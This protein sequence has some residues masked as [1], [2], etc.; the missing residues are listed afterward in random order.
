M[1]QKGA[2]GK[3]GRAGCVEE[4]AYVIALALIAHIIEK[5]GLFLIKLLS[6]FL[7][8]FYTD[9]IFLM[10]ITHSLG[11]VPYNPFKFGTFIL[12]GQCLIH[13][14]LCLPYEKPRVRMIKNVLDFI[15]HAVL[16]QPYTNAAGA[17]GGHL[18]PE[19]LRPVIPDHG[20]LVPTLQPETDHTQAEVLDIFVL[21][22][23]GHLVLAIFFTLAEKKLGNRKVLGDLY[24]GSIHFYSITSLWRI[25]L[26]R[27]NMLLR[28]RD[29]PGPLQ[30][31]HP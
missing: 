10:I 23:H 17:H 15:H 5:I 7:D 16:E 21:F 27:P 11:I 26:L 13:F 20:H 22:P 19:A 6:E 18:G 31:A 8:F 12:Y 14:L 24:P 3:G 4:Q 9:Q 28:H 1:A 2:F 30:A 25:D 29:F